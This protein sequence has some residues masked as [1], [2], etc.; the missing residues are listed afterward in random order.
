MLAGII[1]PLMWLQGSELVWPAAS[2][3]RQAA[4]QR[5]LVE[6]WEAGWHNKFFTQGVMW[7]VHIFEARG[8]KEWGRDARGND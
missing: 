8:A 5:A 4:R 2:A 1:L 3:I 6:T 7:R